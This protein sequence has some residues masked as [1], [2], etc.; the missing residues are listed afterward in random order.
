MARTPSL[1]CEKITQSHIQAGKRQHEEQFGHA[2]G[3]REEGGKA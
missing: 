3:L 2:E 1:S